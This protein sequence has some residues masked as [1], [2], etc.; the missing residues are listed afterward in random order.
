M[1]RQGCVVHLLHRPAGGLMAMQCR[2]QG[3]IQCAMG[4]NAVVYSSPALPAPPVL[5]LCVLEGARVLGCWPF[6][7]QG[8]PCELTLL[9]N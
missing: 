9:P 4:A 6:L 2:G 7:Y 5:L 8:Y 3:D 1:Y